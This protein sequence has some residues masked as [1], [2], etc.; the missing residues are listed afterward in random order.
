MIPAATL[1]FSADYVGAMKETVEKELGGRAVFM[2]GSAGDQSVNAGTN[3]G[4]QAFGQA[5]GREVIKLASSLHPIQD[6]T[7]QLLVI[8]DRLQFTSRT[9]LSDPRVRA[10]YSGASFPELI[11]NFVDEYAQGVSP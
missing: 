10:A 9:D 1:K 6:A 5:L 2:Q 8:E 3:S 11:P 4:Y 7:P